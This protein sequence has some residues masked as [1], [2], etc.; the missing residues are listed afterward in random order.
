MPSAPPSKS[1]KQSC[2]NPVTAIADEVGF[3]D[4]NYFCRVFKKEAD[5]SAKKYRRTIS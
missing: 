2:I 4:Y 1:A 3:C 5:I